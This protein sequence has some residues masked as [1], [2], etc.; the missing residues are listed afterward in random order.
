MSEAA[1]RRASLWIEST[2]E[3]S[4]SSLSDPLDVDVAVVGGGIA[5]I[6]AAFRERTAAH[7]DLVQELTSP[8]WS[9]LPAGK[10][11]ALPEHDLPFLEWEIRAFR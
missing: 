10:R 8:V 6:T 3:T 2:P 7:L 9:E 5:D 4:F 1:S 11:E